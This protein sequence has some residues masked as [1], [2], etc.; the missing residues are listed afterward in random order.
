M[1]SDKK[2]G[3]EGFTKEVDPKDDLAS[4]MV[5]TVLTGVTTELAKTYNS[6]VKNGV[7][8]LQGAVAIPFPDGKGRYPEEILVGLTQGGAPPDIYPKLGNKPGSVD[9]SL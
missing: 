8:L 2:P 6:L 1:T 7:D 3:D 9:P 5:E 4:V